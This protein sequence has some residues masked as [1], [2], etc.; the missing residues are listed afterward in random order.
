MRRVWAAFRVFECDLLRLEKPPHTRQPDSDP[1]LR[2]RRATDLLQ[3]QVRL[4]RR[5]RWCCPSSTGGRRSCGRSTDKSV[6][7]RYAEASESC[8]KTWSDRSA[9][10]GAPRRWRS[11]VSARFFSNSLCPTEVGGPLDTTARAA[12]KMIFSTG[13]FVLVVPRR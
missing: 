1:M 12:S 3:G 11:P 4:F 5:R 2:R 8:Q 13:I 10:G 7:D 9:E 6:R